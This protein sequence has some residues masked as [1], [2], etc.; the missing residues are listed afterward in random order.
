[1]VPKVFERR[2]LRSIARSTNLGADLLQDVGVSGLVDGEGFA[3]VGADDLVHGDGRGESAASFRDFDQKMR[4][5]RKL[6]KGPLRLAEEGFG[7]DD[8]RRSMV[9]NKKIKGP[10][11]STGPLSNT[12]SG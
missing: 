12:T 4:D 11:A 1:M 9:E 8:L 5:D 6:P 3:A 2:A 7:A 10:M